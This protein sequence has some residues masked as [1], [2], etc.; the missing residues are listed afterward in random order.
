MSVAC[1]RVINICTFLCCRLQNNNGKQPSSPKFFM[2]FSKFPEKRSTSQ[3][4][5]KFSKT[6]FE[7]FL[8]HLIL[9]L[10]F[11]G[12]FVWMVRISEIQHFPDFL[13]TFPGN[14][15][16]IR[17][18]SEITGI[19]G[20]MESARRSILQ[21]SV[22]VGQT[23]RTLKIEKH[24]NTTLFTVGA[25]VLLIRQL[26]SSWKRDLYNDPSWILS[27]NVS[28]INTSNVGIDPSLTQDK[29]QSQL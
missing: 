23:S 24:P 20:R 10:E 11:S 29:T 7:N 28:L 16:T 4:K 12:V 8:F 26:L 9:L 21:R 25:D 1:T 14:F 2:L 22:P 15:C 19:F 3:G 6:I 18:C 13:K 27:R 5:P 17:P